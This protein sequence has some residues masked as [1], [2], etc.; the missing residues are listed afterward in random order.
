MYLKRRFF[1][2]QKSERQGPQTRSWRPTNSPISFAY[3]LRQN[4]QFI[5]LPSGWFLVHFLVKTRK[6]IR[7]TVKQVPLKWAA[8]A[9][10]KNNQSEFPRNLPPLII[11]LLRQ[12]LSLAR[13]LSSSQV[14]WAIDHTP[15]IQVALRVSYENLLRIRKFYSILYFTLY[16]AFTN[17][18][19]QVVGR[20][21]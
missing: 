15:I 17:G 21:K 18:F 13:T 10:S 8:R 7:G 20:Q 5:D 4:I 14:N 19:I 11:T 9:C 2:L 3:R 12:A 16:K 1:F 6:T